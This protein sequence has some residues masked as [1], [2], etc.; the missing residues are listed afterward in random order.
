M[1]FLQSLFFLITCIV[2]ATS[3]QKEFSI[4][5]GGVQSAGTLKVDV[6]GECLPSTVHGIYKADSLLSSNSYIE[7]EINVTTPGTYLIKSDTVNGFSFKG[8][9]AVNTTGLNVIRLNAS[10]K[11]LTAGVHTFSIKYNSSI[12]LVDV[13]V[14]SA[15]SPVAIY[16]MTGAPNTCSG[17]VTAGTYKVGVPLDATNTVTMSV[18]VNTPGAYTIAATP[19]NGMYF[20]ASGVFTTTGSQTVVLTGSGTPVNGGATNILTGSGNSNCTFS[21]TVTPAAGGTAAVYTLGGAPGNCTGIVLSGTFTAGVAMAA[22]NTA[23][24]DVNVTTA[25]TYTVTTTAVNG[26]TFAKSGTFATTGTQTIVLTATGTP[27][28]SGPFNYPITGAST[29]CTFPVTYGTGAPPA[30]YTMAGAPG[31]CTPATVGGT[32]TT[33]TAL[34]ASNTVIVQ[35][36]VT[37]IGAYN[38]TTNS[39]NGMTFS[40]SGTFSTTGLQSVTLTGSGTPVTAGI[41]TLTPTIGTSSCTFNVTVVTGGGGTDIFT[42]KVNG[43]LVNFGEFAEGFYFNPNNLLITGSVAGASTEE[44]ILDIDKTATVGTITTGTYVNTLAGSTTGGYIL[45]ASYTDQASVDWSPRSIF[46]PSPDPFTITITS[47]SATRVVGTFSG[48]VRDNFG[49]GTNTKTITE[50]VFNLPIN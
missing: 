41:N 35:V 46:D 39:V 34:S 38:L 12:C 48:T 43:V 9:G 36:N 49:T 13:E 15:S 3:C 10:G 4:E 50:G 8:F 42:A 37:T 14:I 40:K 20:S 11:P 45:G 23:T 28:A 1:K 47:I 31:A 17:A 18:F 30:V 24:V 27:T 2:M 32:Y 26:V 44:M 33:G 29:S 16:Q 5:N 19:N 7:V 25:G 22:T 6:T 21:I